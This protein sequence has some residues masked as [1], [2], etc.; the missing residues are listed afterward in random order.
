MLLFQITGTPNIYVYIYISYTP[1]Y[2][3][4]YEGDPPQKDTHHF[5][6]PSHGDAICMMGPPWDALQ[7]Q[8]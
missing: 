3:D 1:K 4:P 7:R 8:T 2:Y 5:G 6:K